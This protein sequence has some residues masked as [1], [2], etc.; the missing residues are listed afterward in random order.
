MRKHLLHAV[1]G[2]GLA[3]IVLA[4]ASPVFAAP[5]KG[6][7]GG[8][9]PKQITGEITKVDA[10]SITVKSKKEEKTLKV[11]ADTKVSTA[12]N[13][14]AKVADLKVGDKVV[15]MFTD[16]DVCTKISPPAPPKKKEATQ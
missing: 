15:A 5:G 7:G 13:Q 16:D 9:H 4:F 12:A 2:L 6:G 8:A 11:T 10:S 1:A 14:V 3:A